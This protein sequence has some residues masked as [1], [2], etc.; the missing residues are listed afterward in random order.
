MPEYGKE[1]ADRYRKYE[2]TL[3][4]HHKW[5]INHTIEYLGIKLEEL[6]HYMQIDVTTL[7]NIINNLHDED[8]RTVLALT[9]YL[10]MV[11]EWQTKMPQGEIKELEVGLS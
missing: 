10:L 1:L 6:A 11:K 7:N 4:R 5:V 8:P 9:T 3:L 2:D